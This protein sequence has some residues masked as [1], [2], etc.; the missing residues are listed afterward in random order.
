MTHD[1]YCIEVCRGACCYNNEMACPNLCDGACSIHH[2]WVNNSCGVASDEFKTAPIVEA[3]EK[4]WVPKNIV[5]KCCYA[6]PGL[7]E[8]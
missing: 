5:E 2:L 6:H 4:G 7:L 1:T 3:L 8:R